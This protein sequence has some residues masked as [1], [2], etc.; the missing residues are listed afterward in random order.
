[1]GLWVNEVVEYDERGAGQGSHCTRRGCYRHF[2]A[3]DP[4]NPNGTVQPDD[5][6]SQERQRTS[7]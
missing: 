3:L 1:M 6:Q 7:G 4:N 5:E 2:S